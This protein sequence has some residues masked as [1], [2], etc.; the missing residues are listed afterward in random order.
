M[1]LK[2]TVLLGVFILMACTESDDQVIESS[3]TI[4]SEFTVEQSANRFEDIVT[5]KGLTVFNR[6][7]HSK[8]A[9]GVDLTLR[10][11]QLIIFGNPKV[12]TPLMQCSQLAALD[13]PQKALF[14][15]DEAGK[16]WLTY[17]NPAYLKAR[18]NINGCD[19]VL[20]KVTNV[21][22]GLSKAAATKE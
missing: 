10:P 20:T 18:H 7:D 11:T 13:L 15:E 6:I 17:N 8:N 1:K 9:A 19:E 2:L 14:W 21:L 3:I 12:G 4:A 22:A 5:K 16:V